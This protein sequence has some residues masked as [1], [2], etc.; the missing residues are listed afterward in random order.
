MADESDG[1]REIHAG[2]LVTGPAG[3]DSIPILLMAGE[4]VYGPDGKL[5]LVAVGTPRETT[6]DVPRT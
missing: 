5:L 4:H 6:A 2:G 3:E 1:E